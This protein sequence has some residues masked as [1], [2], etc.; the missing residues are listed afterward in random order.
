MKAWWL[1]YRAAGL[2][3]GDVAL[4]VLIGAMVLGPLIWTPLGPEFARAL[5][6]AIRR[7]KRAG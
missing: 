2:G 5:A 4:G 6:K 3:A 1:R 7:G